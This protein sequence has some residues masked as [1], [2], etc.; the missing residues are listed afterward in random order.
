MIKSYFV[1]AIRNLMRNKAYAAINI[2]GLALGLASFLIILFYVKKELSYDQFHQQHDSIY[3]VTNTFERSTGFMYWVRT[4][5]ALA[6]AIRTNLP[7]IE[8]VCRLR[9]AD[10]HTY[11]VKDRVFR[12]GNVFY[13]DSSFLD[14]FDFKLIAGNASK[15]LTQPG[16][17]VITQEMATKYFGDQDALGELIT[18]DNNQNLEVTGI[19]ENLPSSSHITFDMLISFE[20]YVVPSGY[21]ADLTSWGWAGFHTYILLSPDVDPINANQQIDDLYNQNFNPANLSVNTELQPLASLYLE[22]GKYTNMGE[23]ILTGN[24]STI[25]GLAMVALLVLAIASFNFMNITTALSLGRGKE[26]GIRK[27]MGSA[28]SKIAL[29]FLVESVV[30]SLI[31]F[32]VALV[33]VFM[34]QPYFSTLLGGSILPLPDLILYIPL[35][36]MG[37]ILLGMLS[38]GYPAI[39]LAA[40]GVTAALRGTL[41][42]G[43][44][45][46]ALRNMLMVF[47]F[48]VSIT[49]IAGSIIIITQMDFIRNKHL[50]F[51]KE[52][53]L[54]IKILEDD[55]A[56]HYRALKT[57]FQEHPNVLEVAISSHAF[58]GSSSSGPAR[59][60]GAPEDESYQVG[61]YQ[62]DHDFIDLANIELVAGRYFSQDFPSDSTAVVL[63]ETAVGIMGLEDP[64]GTIL[65]FTGAERTVIGVVKDFHFRS[66]HTDI[67]PLALVMPFGTPENILVKVSAGN[68]FRTIADLEASWKSIVDHSP[69]E[70]TLLEDNIEQMYVQESKLASLINIFG[71]LAIILACLGLY[72]LVAFSVQAR[73]REVGIR[74]VL[75]SS[76]TSLLMVLSSKFVLLITIAVVIACPAIFYLGNLW[77][78]GFAYRIG[79]EWWIYAGASLVLL[80]IALVTISGQTIK[81][82]LINPVEVLRNE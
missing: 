71:G 31:S 68:I 19:L 65:S 66:L 8:K 43:K 72:G 61:Y 33:F 82:A 2:L 77:L 20:T 1:I 40:F 12:Q 60:Q 36:V 11:S 16:S 67:G 48:V 30:V 76:M 37:V 39:M 78:D 57:K 64:V 28:R 25:Y 3:R 53:T 45:G 13:A 69:F 6:P 32:V 75:G 73:L 52:N 59:L 18:F 15:A 44:R 55:M 54:Q 74:K 50:G 62:T 22:S 14:I 5:P 49:L 24:R 56:N 41:K 26:I 27:V 21:L 46:A 38:G 34:S 79:V 9:Y 23:S 47:Q 63:N 4:P 29:Q 17:I 58:G 35:L 10:D 42:A 7:G 80:L 51:E 70:M 81:T